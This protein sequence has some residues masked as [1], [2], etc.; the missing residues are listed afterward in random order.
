VNVLGLLR[1]LSLRHFRRHALRTI[2]ALAS[3]ALGVGAFLAMTALNRGVLE[4]FERTARLRAAGADA[5]V[6]AGSVGVPAAL[7]VELRKVAGVRGAT[8]FV[9]RPVDLAI[10]GEPGGKLLGVRLIGLDP[11]G[12]P[13]DLL[14]WPRAAVERLASPLFAR[15]AGGPVPVVLPRALA[16]GW[17]HEDG[18]PVAAGDV[19]EL[20][21]GRTAA[22]VR[23]AA[24]VDESGFAGDAPADFVAASLPDALRLT[25][26]GENGDTLL[27]W[28]SLPAEP[29]AADRERRDVDARVR[30]ALAGRAELCDPL[31]Q[32]REFDATLGSFRV[33]LR[34]V[35]LLS[36]VI[37]AFLVHSTLAMALVERQ[38][39]FAIVRCVGMTAG[40]LGS[41]LVTEAAVVGAAG[42]LLG[43][44]L[45]KGMA[46]GMA[47]LFW[48]TVGQTFDRIEVVVRAPSAGE[49]A[50][51]VA[52]GLMAALVAVARPVSSAA[53]LAPLSG[54]VAAR[55]SGRAASRA[56]RGA[57]ALSV[58]TFS[59]ALVLFVGRGFAIPYA[60]YAIALL[61]VA[62]LALGSRS[63]L[64]WL[65]RALAPPLI[66]VAGVA[67]RLARD[68]L[69]RSA[70]HA[71][72]TVVAIALAF[73]L[74]FSTDVLVKSYVGMLDRWFIANVGED[75]LVM[76]RDF[77]GSGMI[78]SDFP[79]AKNGELAAIP[80][81]LHSHGLRFSRIQHGGER[82]LLFSYDAGSPVEAG[83]P[84]FV[85]GGPEDQRALARGEG[86]FVSE[87]FARRFR[88]GRGDR[89]TLSSP[90]GPLELPVLAVVEDYMW[91]RG[92]I[93]IDD[94]RYRAAFHDLQVQEF[95]LTLDGSRPLADVQR[96]VE[97]VMADH[98]G[99]VIADAGT[100]Q[101]NVMQVVERYWS[102]L[103]AQ[104]GL[105]V[106]VA[107]LGTLHALLVSV[108]LRRRELALLRALGAPLPLVGRMLCIEGVLLG[109]SGG[110][111]G[112][113]FGSFAAAIA[114]K[115][116]SIEEM[117]FAVPLLPSWPMALL[118][119]LAATFTGWLAGLLPGRRAVAAAPRTALLDTIG[120]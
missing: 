37:A 30:A 28:Y 82:V 79:G 62:A 69:R 90:D 36:L 10:E 92:S 3:V 110:L 76:G 63:L 98:P 6:T 103:L 45:G 72:L 83:E 51:G 53:R 26:G 91:P 17:R 41:F 38:R 7:A 27:L 60:G 12:L 40:R 20:E 80:G 19:L 88:R 15:L 95:A 106:A 87:G 100:V 81:V 120:G 54:L 16:D 52:A 112:V 48:G 18:R 58:V 2:L 70:D 77:I 73:G 114:L 101:R 56:P 49:C 4:S 71:A 25:D 109:L 47:R 97:R 22:R 5:V 44:P 65:L 93:W 23:V 9:M 46:A 84:E 99:C 29:A 86:C 96:D 85:D 105:A 116:L 34:F 11:A 111:L 66:A 75:L 108:L 61:L 55:G 35:A 1:L 14:P 8:P 67:A 39:D 59:A 50:L 118:T 107:F 78:G 13:D 68:H 33:A 102:L 117:G 42:G 24:V 89:V 119:V 64:G 94:D 32:A 115:V 43:L 113:G 21:A 31:G 74:C 104:E 57:I